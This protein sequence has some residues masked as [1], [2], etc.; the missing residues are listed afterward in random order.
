[1]RKLILPVL[2]A[3][4]C[5]ALPAVAQAANHYDITANFTP[6]KSGT[7]S[8]PAPVSGN[9]G[10]KVTDTEGK[11]PFALD[12]L[13]VDFT[14]MRINTGQFKTCTPAAIEQAQSD[15][16]CNPAALVATGYA[17]NIAGNAATRDDASLR[18]YLSVKLYNSGPGKA[19]LFVKGDPAAAQSCPIAV[20]T[21]I[22]VT[23]KRGAT[24]DSLSF[25]IPT[26]LKNPVSTIRNSLVET[27]LTLKRKTVKVGGKTVGYFETFG[28]CKAGARKITV[29]FDNEGAND[30]VQSSAAR[31]SA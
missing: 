24:G 18:C 1:M 9:F 12:S 15:R 11:R 30:M 26:N 19:A 14:G 27:Q 28:G 6:G 13:K 29:A 31:C 25:A 23:I 8:R 7:K 16:V 3:T 22:P 4:F 20:A 10:F 21:A 17:N 2:A 5:L